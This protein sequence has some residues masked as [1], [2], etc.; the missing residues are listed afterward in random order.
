MIFRILFLVVFCSNCYTRGWDGTL[1]KDNSPIPVQYKRLTA[2][3]Y[4]HSISIHWNANQPDFFSRYNS[5]SSQVETATDSQIGN[6]LEKSGFFDHVIESPNAIPFR[7]HRIDVHEIIKTNHEEVVG[8][9]SSLVL[10]LGTFGFVP[11]I[12]IE[13][14][15]YNVRI[16]EYEKLIHSFNDYE[17][18]TYIYSIFTLPGF[19]SE[20][21]NPWKAN[22]TLRE[23]LAMKILREIANKKLLPEH[24]MIEKK[25]SKK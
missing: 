15:S 3:T 1:I 9:V 12:K 2:I 10:C 23:E 17:R 24:S 8:F 7:K 19:F 20:N 14:H 11:T 13:H 22:T 6:I 18:L 21:S 5:Y 4:I 25:D 16:Y